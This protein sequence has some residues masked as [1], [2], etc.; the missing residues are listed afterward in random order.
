MYEAVIILPFFDLHS[1]LYHFIGR[2][3]DFSSRMGKAHRLCF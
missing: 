1:W 2:L 3:F